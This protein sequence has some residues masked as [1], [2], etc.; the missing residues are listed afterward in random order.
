[1]EV[2]SQLSWMSLQLLGVGGFN[3]GASGWNGC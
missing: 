1:L 2:Y 3:L